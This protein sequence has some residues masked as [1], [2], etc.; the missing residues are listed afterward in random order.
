MHRHDVWFCRGPQTHDRVPILLL[1]LG[2]GG[3][4][5][6]GSPK[7]YDRPAT[8]TEHRIDVRVEQERRH[9]T[10]KLGHWAS[11]EVRG[12][13]TVL[14][15]RSIRICTC[16][17]LLTVHGTDQE[18]EQHASFKSTEWTFWISETDADTALDGLLKHRV[19]F[20]YIDHSVFGS[21][22]M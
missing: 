12:S 7:F 21:P 20:I 16:S 18:L 22:C 13:V 11:G 4:I 15:S 3:P 14:C 9:R 19:W 17:Y 2:S 1:S 6:M 5:P 10:R 8:A